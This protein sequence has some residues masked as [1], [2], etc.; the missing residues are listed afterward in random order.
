M[1]ELTASMFGAVNAV[2]GI[3]PNGAGNVPLNAAHRIRVPAPNQGIGQTPVGE[4]VNTLFFDTAA[5]PPV[6]SV[7][8]YIEIERAGGSTVFLRSKADGS[9]VFDD[10]AAETTLYSPAQPSQ[11]HR[12]D[13]EPCQ[14]CGR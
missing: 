3:P 11:H 4:T 9:F 2:D 6:V 7:D 12:P 13:G 14:P 5:T 10:G 1:E 8:E